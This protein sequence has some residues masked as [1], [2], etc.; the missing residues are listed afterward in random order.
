MITEK[1]NNTKHVE[2]VAAKLRNALSPH[3]GLPSVIS[4]LRE[5]PEILKIVEDMAEQAIKNNLMIDD[6]LKQIDA[7]YRKTE[8]DGSGREMEFAEWILEQ[9]AETSDSNS[10]WI[11]FGK[12]WPKDFYTTSDLFQI[13]LSQNP[14]P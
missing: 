10:S 2:T 8:I 5:H 6:L 14:K 9:G 1:T 4:K 12:K 13:F 11:L 7:L 3:Y